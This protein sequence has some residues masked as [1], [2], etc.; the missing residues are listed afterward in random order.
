MKIVGFVLKEVAKKIK[1]IRTAYKQEVRKIMKSKT[2]GSSS[3]QYVQTEGPM[4]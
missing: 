3:R 1:N 2:S 4:V